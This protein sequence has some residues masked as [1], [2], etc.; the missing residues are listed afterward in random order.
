MFNVEHFVEKFNAYGILCE[1]NYSLKDKNTYKTGG[2]AR[3]AI[4]PDTTQKVKDALKIIKQENI[5]YSVIGAGSNLL[6]S[7]EGYEGVLIFT[8]DLKGITVNG[9]LVTCFAG[10]RVSDFL[11]QAL[12]NSLGGVEFL[13]GI[14]ASVGGVVTMNAGCFGKN[15][16]DYVSYVVTANGIFSFADCDFGYR[17]SRFKK[18]KD[19][20]ISV[21]F[22]LENVEY[23]QS[24]SKT[25]YFL[26]LRKNKQPKGRSC[27]SVFKNDGYYAGKV[28]E[29]C[30]LK[31]YKIG[32]ARV[33]ERHANF[34]LADQNAKSADISRL[35]KHIK[36]TV[37]EKCGIILQEEIEY[38]GKFDN[39]NN[40]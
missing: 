30:N 10:E 8:K 27:G 18:E 6:V 5:D 35:I 24:E 20:V 25:E 39:E 28:I 7:D 15:V 19:I 3:L 34:I 16:G 11:K 32:S 33:S 38:L 36:K 23:D 21:C 1:Q 22:N 9:N 40:A 37:K 29:S 12:Y 26:K 14:P 13:S 31:G 17:T 2:C 4:F